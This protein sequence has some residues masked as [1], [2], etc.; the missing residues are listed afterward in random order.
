MRRWRAVACLVA[1]AVPPSAAQAQGTLGTAFTYQGRMTNAG[2]PASGSYDLLFILFDADAGGSQVGPN[3]TKPGVA[4]TSGLFTVSLDFGAAFTGGKRWLEIAVRPGGS[5]GDYTILSPRQELTPSPNALFSAVTGDTTVQRRSVPPTCPAGQY[6]Q[7]LAPDGTP[8]CGFDT[9][10]GGTVVSVETGAGLTGGPIS[11]SGTLAVEREGITQQMIAKGAVG[12][13]QIARGA[14]G[15]EQIDQSQVQTRVGGTCPAGQYLRGINANGTVVC[16]PFLAANVISTVDDPANSVGPYTSIA[17]GTD[18]LPI[19]SY[20]D[21][22]A[23]ALKV[24]KCGNATCTIGNTITTVDDPIGSQ[25]GAY[26]SIAIGADGLP[27]ISYF[28]SVL[29]LTVAHC[30]NAACTTG[31]AIDV[32]DPG[33]VGWYTSIAIGSDNLPVISYKDFGA[34]RLKV[35]HCGDAA[36]SGGNVAAVVDD[37]ANSVGTQTSIAI[38]ADGLPVISYMDDTAAALKVAHCGN[39]DCTAGNAITT[40]DDPANVVGYFSS[41]AIGSDS[42][43]VISYFDYTA[44]ALKV[45]HCGN[46]ACTAGNVIAIVD[47]PGNSVGWFDSLVIGTDGLPVISYYDNTALS[48]KVAHCG[49]AACTAANAITTVDDP[50]NYVGQYT[51]LAIGTDGL[52]VISYQDV[53]ANT[54]KVAKC[55]TRT[56][57]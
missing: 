11:T 57:Q 14:V 32:V 46:V 21:S 42:L 40:V 36:C 16:E 52:P 45:A 7:S 48:L 26:T 41:I 47:A 43:P 12:S 3:V 54:L 33:T 56:C 35:A 55:G 5:T 22:T 6:L 23:F 31:N 28:D 4:V 51:S 1:V 17:I 8:T 15:L 20:Y 50:A 49:N 27:V 39:A 9:N 25:A 24:L 10:S 18:S 2:T 44:G 53:T 30:G 13:A 37:P 38:G 34:N 29:G 19:I